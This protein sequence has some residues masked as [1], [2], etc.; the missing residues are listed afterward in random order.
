MVS[1][2]TWDS[3]LDVYYSLTVT[4]LFLW[5]ALSDERMGLSLLYAAD[6]LPAQSFSCPSPLGLATVF[7]CIIC[8]TSLFVASYHS[9]GHGGGMRLRLH[10]G[11]NWNITGVALYVLRADLTETPIPLLVVTDRTENMSQEYHAEDK[12]RDSH[13]VSLLAR[14]P[15]P[16]NE[17]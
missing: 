7:Y 17:L 10:T 15:S 1:S 16:S 9:Q 3:W 2:S 5:G 13:W 6:P 8:E 4:V 11:R 12:S 14:W